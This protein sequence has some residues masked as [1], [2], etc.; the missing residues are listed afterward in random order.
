MLGRLSYGIYLW[1]WPVQVF[2]ADRFRLDGWTLDL[3]VVLG[4][5]ALAALSFALVE[6]PIRTGRP[7]PRPWAVRSDGPVLPSA[8]VGAM[9][10][11]P[12]LSGTASGVGGIV[13]SLTDGVEG[14]LVPPDDPAT[15][16]ARLALLLTDTGMSSV[17]KKS[18]RNDAIGCSRAVMSTWR[19]SSRFLAVWSPCC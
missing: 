17:P 6:D 19:P 8:T 3:V 10:L 9:A 4:S 13:E 12:E 11:R 2:A 16:A 15:L 7:I 18:C 5:L 1:S 14:F